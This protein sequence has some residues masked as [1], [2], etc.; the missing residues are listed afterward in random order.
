MAPT[1]S[2]SFPLTKPTILERRHM[3]QSELFAIE[4]L[5]LRF[6]NG[7]QRTFERLKGKGRGAVSCAVCGICMCG[8]MSL[9]S[10]GVNRQ[11]EGGVSVAW[12]VCV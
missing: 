3:A 10:D 2:P 1:D 7:E 12:C 8:V 4:S 11:N 9:K 5:D 6:A